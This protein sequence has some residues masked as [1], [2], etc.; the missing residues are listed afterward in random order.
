MDLFEFRLVSLRYFPD[1]GKVHDHAVHRDRYIGK[2]V[3]EVLE[4][5]R[6][7]EKD[8]SVRTHD[9]A[10]RLTKQDPIV[11]ILC[12]MECLVRSVCE[13]DVFPVLESCNGSFESQLL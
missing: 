6:V 7:A 13:V 2:D 5:L 4:P 11:G 12:A 1:F 9:Q 8:A 10:H 3:L